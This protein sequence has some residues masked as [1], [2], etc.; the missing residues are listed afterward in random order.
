MYEPGGTLGTVSTQFEIPPVEFV[1]QVFVKRPVVVTMEFIGYPIPVAV[2]EAPM[3]PRTGLSFRV[4]AA[5]CD[6][7]TRADADTRH[8]MINNETVNSFTNLGFIFFFAFSF[9]LGHRYQ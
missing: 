1:E 3:T 5:A 9:C 4:V 8:S 2:T 7:N 6:G